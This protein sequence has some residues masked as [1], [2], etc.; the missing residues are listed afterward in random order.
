M[1]TTIKVTPLDIQQKRFHLGFRGY[2]RTEVEMFLDLVRDQMEDLVREV[3]ELRE[4]RQSYEERLREL[5]GKEET[6][7]NTLLMTQKLIEELKENSRKEAA[8]IIKDAEVRNQ[9]IV[10]NAQ[11][12]KIKLEGEILELKRRKHHFLQDVNKVIQMHLEM[13][14]YETGT[15]EIREEPVQG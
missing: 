3:T 10:V 5:N 11:Q 12:E 13:V 15:D 8:L 14:N 2:E 9:Q 4:F 7:K 1:S 6:V